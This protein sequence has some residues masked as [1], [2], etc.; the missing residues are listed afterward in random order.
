MKENLKKLKKEYE[1]LQKRYRLPSFSAL[2]KEFE[3]EKI[4]DRETEFL[5]REIRR[6]ISEKVAAF[7][8]FLELFFNPTVAPFFV[9]TSIKSLSQ[10]DK[11]LIERIYKELAKIQ[12]NSLALDIE[13]NESKEAMFIKEVWKKWKELKPDLKEFSKILLGFQTKKRKGYVG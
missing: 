12:L 8:H 1:K 3:I 7:L 10:S 9:L 11:E 4:Q 6:I 13:T 5:L 2:N